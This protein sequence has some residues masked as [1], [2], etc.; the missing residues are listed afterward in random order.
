MLICSKE[1]QGIVYF[2]HCITIYFQP[3][4]SNG[5]TVLTTPPVPDK[6][7]VIHPNSTGTPITLLQFNWTAFTQ[8]GLQASGIQDKLSYGPI[9]HY[10]WTVIVDYQGREPNKQLMPWQKV[11]ASDRAQVYCTLKLTLASNINMY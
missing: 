1:L 8:P 10:E 9:S 7:N 2:Y 5:F 6:L 11:N 4:Y 3:V